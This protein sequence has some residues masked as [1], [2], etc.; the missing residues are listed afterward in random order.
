MEMRKIH[1]IWK[2]HEFIAT[3]QPQGGWQ[4]EITSDTDGR[5]RLTQTFSTLEDAMEAA[6]GIADSESRSLH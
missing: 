3:E 2:D 4:V 6:R 1:A 5:S